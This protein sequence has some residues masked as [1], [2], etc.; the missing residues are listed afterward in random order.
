MYV[1]D[2]FIPFV[3]TLAEEIDVQL[4]PEMEPFN[5]ER[6]FTRFDYRDKLRG[7]FIEEAKVLASAIG[8]PFLS[9]DEGRDRWDLFP[10]DMNDIYKPLNSVAGGGPQAS[11]QNPIETPGEQPAGITPGGGTAPADEGKALNLWLDAE[12]KAWLDA[13]ERNTHQQRVQEV[14]RRHLSRQERTVVSLAGA[15]ARRASVTVEDVYIDEER[16]DRELSQ[17]FEGLGYNGD[18]VGMARK[19]NEMTKLRLSEALLTGADLGSAFRWDEEV[20]NG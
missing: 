13:E 4:L 11:P 12:T 19:I 9:V 2:R 18:S 20:L 8:G 3:T 5:Y 16:W 1:Q 10:K 15:L 6:Q 17:D 7:S 14:V